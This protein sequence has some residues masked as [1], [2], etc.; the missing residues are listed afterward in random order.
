MK[1]D[2]RT[3]RLLKNVGTTGKQLKSIVHRQ[4]LA[5]CAIGI[6]I[7]LPY[8]YLVGLALAPGRQHD[9]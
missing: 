8:G 6:P 1:N 9:A 2:I 7:G 4:A 5:L 3:Y